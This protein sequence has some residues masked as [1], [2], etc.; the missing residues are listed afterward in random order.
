MTYRSRFK[1]NER[2]HQIALRSDWSFSFK[3]AL[4]GLLIGVL[5]VPML[6]ADRPELAPLSR[7]IE[8]IAW[9]FTVI[10]AGI[11]VRRWFVQRKETQQSENGVADEV[12]ADDR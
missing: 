10:F 1:R 12:N 8:V 6:L 11:G 5:A 9:L 7:T 4:C 2:L 3:L